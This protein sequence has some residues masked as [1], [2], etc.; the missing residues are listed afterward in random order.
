MQWLKRW[1]MSRPFAFCFL[2]VFSNSKSLCFAGHYIVT[3]HCVKSYQLNRFDSTDCKSIAYLMYYLTTFII[4]MIVSIFTIWNR[5]KK[6]EY[7]MKL[8]KN[9]WDLKW[10]LNWPYLNFSSNRFLF[11]PNPPP[12]AISLLFVTIFHFRWK[13]RTVKERVRKKVWKM[14]QTKIQLNSIKSN[15]YVTANACSMKCVPTTYISRSCLKFV[16]HS[17]NSFWFISINSLSAL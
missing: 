9:E 3:T 15:R 4:Q 14:E 10:Q 12:V 5:I 1:V 13:I 7:R 11:S 2:F 6:R 17:S 16:L 8:G